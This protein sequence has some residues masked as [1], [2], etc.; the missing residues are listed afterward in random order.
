MNTQTLV[1]TKWGI[2][3]THS[4][5]HFKVKHMMVST[6]SGAFKNFEGG[7][8]SQGETPENAKIWFSA[9]IDSIDTNN[10]QRDAHLKSDDFF[11]AE[12][13]PS[14]TFSSSRMIKKSEGKYEMIGDL[15]I[16]DI[17]KEIKLD[18]EYFGTAVDPY[19]QMKA[20]FEINGAISR[21]AFGLKWNAL[22]ET[23]GVVV[24]DDVKL[25]MNIQLVQE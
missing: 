6:V 1:S 13:Y 25:V 19:G 4:E 17:T 18:V 7:M 24:S 16:R 22:T 20:G 21:K 8:E 9:D 15:T 11:N 14:L 3:T 12:K 23:G 2:D 5:V 10:E